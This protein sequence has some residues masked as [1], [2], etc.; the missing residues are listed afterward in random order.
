MPKQLLDEARVDR[1]AFQATSFS[2]A[3]EADLKYW[4]SHTQ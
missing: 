2:E 1:R 4:R 3:E